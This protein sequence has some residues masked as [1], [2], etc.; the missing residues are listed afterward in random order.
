[1]GWLDI[2]LS[3]ADAIT[4]GVEQPLEINFAG[5]TGGAQNLNQTQTPVVTA[6]P[7]LP[8]TGGGTI[9]SPKS[10]TSSSTLW[11]LLLGGGGAILFWW[12]NRKGK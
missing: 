12:F 10:A 8:S 1:M 5:S 3:S 2:G 9:A 6:S 11:L 4:T 7:A